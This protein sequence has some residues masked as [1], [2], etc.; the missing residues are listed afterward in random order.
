MTR[1]SNRLLLTFGLAS[2]AAV[3]TGAFV[4]AQ[5]GVPTGLWLRNLIAWSMGGLV[6]VAISAARPGPAAAFA[7]LAAPA[8]LAASLISRDQAGVHRWVDLGPLHMNV[9]MVLAPLAVVALAAS[10][11]ATR[12]PWV[13]ALIT[14]GL[15]VAQPD[16]SQATA[17]AASVALIASRIARPLAARGAVIAVA[18]LLAAAAWLRPDP[19]LPVP[20]VEEVI[21]LANTLSPLAAV[22]ASALLAAASL[23]PLVLTRAAQPQPRLAG[24]ALSVCFLLWSATPWIGA[25]PVPWVGIGMS[26][27]LGG[28]L[29]VGLLAALV[30]RLRTAPSPQSVVSSVSAPGAFF[31]MLSMALLAPAFEA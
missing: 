3:T 8:G 4:C 23:A 1:L 18:G 15:L 17:F 11:G 21:G 26:P 29:G 27:I 24:Q 10:G 30:R 20:E 13:A 12:W 7:L 9:A 6:A 16:A 22:L 5:S 14:L 19:L 25:F 28:W 2:L 31:L